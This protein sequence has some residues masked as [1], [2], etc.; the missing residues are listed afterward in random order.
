M[1]FQSMAMQPDLRVVS[2]IF[3]PRDELPAYDDANGSQSVCLKYFF[4]RGEPPAY[5]D[6]NGSQSVCLKYFFPGENYQP[7]TI[8]Q[9]WKVSV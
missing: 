2:K 6:A 5:D 8:Q 7:T 4:P 1:N 3:F 9:D